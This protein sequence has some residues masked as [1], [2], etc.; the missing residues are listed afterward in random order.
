MED[1]KRLEKCYALQL[2]RGCYAIGG[3]VVAP[4]VGEDG[5]VVQK[6]VKNRDSMNDA[7]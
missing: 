4:R 1:I 5:V 3:R 2:Q 7:P 6:S